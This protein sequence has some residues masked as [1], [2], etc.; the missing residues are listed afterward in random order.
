MFN[1]KDLEIKAQEV[2]ERFAHLVTFDNTY[3]FNGRNAR[4][5]WPSRFQKISVLGGNV[6]IIF[7]EKTITFRIEYK[8]TAST[9]DLISNLLKET[10]KNKSIFNR[11]K[12]SNESIKIQL[13]P[14]GNTDGGLIVWNNVKLKKVENNITKFD[15]NN[16]LIETTLTYSFS[17][18]DF[19]Y[20]SL[21]MDEINKCV[22]KKSKL[23]YE[24]LCLKQNNNENCEEKQL[25]NPDDISKNFNVTV[26]KINDDEKICETNQPEESENKSTN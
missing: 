3:G 5:S 26:I 9:V 12:K 16:N 7:N 19:K 21:A 1:I 11:F 15:S 22:G 2:G 17:D 10:K 25:D 23:V 20:L 13:F 8:P 14:K 4:I 18:I 24:G 6:K